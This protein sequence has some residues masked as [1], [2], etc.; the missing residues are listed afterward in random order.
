MTAQVTQNPIGGPAENSIPHS[1]LDF[2]E[3]S[4]SGFTNLFMMAPRYMRSAFQKSTKM[5]SADTCKKNGRKG[6]RPKKDSQTPNT[7]THDIIFGAGQRW[8]QG[9]GPG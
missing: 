5:D 4:L 7:S 9:P 1:S 8:N 6:P 2:W 3:G